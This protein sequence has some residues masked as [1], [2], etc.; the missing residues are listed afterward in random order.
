M[1]F[2]L[3]TCLVFLAWF[4]R[5]PAAPPNI[6]FIMTDQHSADALSCRMGDRYLKTPALD[7]L[8]ARGTFFSRAYT[9]NPLCM[10]ARNSI[11]TGRYPHETGITDNTKTTL[12]ASEFVTMGTY[13][14]QA[15]Y[16]TAYFGKWHLAYNE[17]ATKTHGFETLETGHID[18]ENAALATKFLGR[19]HEKPFLLVVSFLNP[20]NVCELARDQQLNNGPIGEPPPVAQRPPA[21]ANLAPPQNEPDTMARI[22]AGYHANPAFPVGNFSP[23]RWQALRWGY[24]RLIEKV[25]AE[26]GK[27][28]DAL[29]AAGLEENTL[30][31]FT[32]DHG[33]CAGAHGFNQKTVFYEESARVPFIVSAPGQRVGRVSEKFTNTG[34]DILPTMLDFASLAKPAKLSGASLRSL[35]QGQPV[36]PWRDDVVVQN[37]MSQTFAVEGNVP[38][39]EGRMLRTDRYKYCVYVHGQN[40]ESLVDLE[41]DPGEMTNLARDPAHRD[42]LLA[43]RERLRKWGVANG[44]SLVVEM[45]ADDVKPREFAV[46]KTPKNAARSEGLAK[47]KKAK[48][49]E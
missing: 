12:N 23:E 22:R 27:V 44:D 18:A 13:F 36:A 15:G 5:S 37:N 43:M 17:G 24:Y 2:P 19:K 4:A 21:P 20:H 10:P 11:F 6:V 42:T 32:A 9:P 35:A 14:L 41:K 7:R 31:V 25:D 46:V 16:Q 30:I 34:T 29:K 40:R 8:A 26:I 1:K 39:T 33:E 3:T 49:H 38:T 28:L 45:L 47:Q 48:A